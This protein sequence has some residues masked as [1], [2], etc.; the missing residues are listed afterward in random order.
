MYI[1][2]KGV[3]MRKQR[4]PDRPPMVSFMLYIDRATKK[5]AVKMSNKM[6][7]SLASIMRSLLKEWVTGAKT[8]EK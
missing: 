1:I 7:V 2:N 5:E 6:N 8:D 4:Y 3:I